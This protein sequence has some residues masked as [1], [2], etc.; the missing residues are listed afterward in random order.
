MNKPPVLL[1]YPL[2]RLDTSGRGTLP[3][4]L[5][6]RLINS[7]GKHIFLICIAIFI[8]CNIG[9]KAH[10]GFRTSLDLP[11]VL[12][13]DTDL[14]ERYWEWLLRQ[15]DAPEDVPFP[16]IRVEPMT[17]NIRMQLFHPTRLDRLES[18]RIA[19]SPHSIKRAEQG[20]Q[21]VVLSE[22]GHELVHH[23]LL[24]KENE[25]QFGKTF[26][27]Q[28]QHHHCDQEF[29]YLV[30][31]VGQII[32]N[33]YHSADLV[34]SVDQMNRRACWENGDSLAESD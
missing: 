31:G 8:F 22:I 27:N 14:L 34:R 21:L 20:Q 24:L 2:F 1:I 11:A 15:T 23:I 18:W 7:L 12:K 30:T 10:A 13:K 4:A 33:A 17:R 29:Q 9:E 16:D 3:W 19:I 5:P 26:Y 6:K 28:P 25:W 32:W